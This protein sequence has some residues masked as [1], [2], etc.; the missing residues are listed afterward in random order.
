MT[1]RVI[2]ENENIFD[3]PDGGSCPFNIGGS[4]D[5]L[6][7]VT[8][9][10]LDIP[11]ITG[12]VESMLEFVAA[13]V[14]DIDESIL[15]RENTFAA[16]FWVGGVPPSIELFNSVNKVSGMVKRANEA[17]RGWKVN[18]QNTAARLL[19]ELGNYESVRSIIESSK[20]DNKDITSHGGLK[21]TAKVAASQFLRA[22]KSLTMHHKRL[23]MSN[24]KINIIA[25][26]LRSMINGFVRGIIPYGTEGDKVLNLDEL[27][28]VLESLNGTSSP[29]VNVQDELA[30]I[31]NDGQLVF[32]A[33]ARPIGDIIERDANGPVGDLERRLALAGGG[34]NAQRERNLQSL[35]RAE[36]EVETSL[37]MG[38][39]RERFDKII[40]TLSG[41]FAGDDRIMPRVM[42]L[43]SRIR[44]QSPT[45]VMARLEI[46]IADATVDRLVLRNI[47][48]GILR[49]IRHMRDAD[50][51]RDGF[52]KLLTDVNSQIAHAEHAEN[53]E[54][55]PSGSGVQLPRQAEQP[56]EFAQS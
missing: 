28:A 46:A 38:K 5:P 56:M 32:H 31:V 37:Y 24:A 8:T 30:R 10:F 54:Y 48:N 23:R 41:I 6:I 19:K 44:A 29:L 50:V 15:T 52:G 42:A 55:G 4:G 22:A 26:E 7:T 12:Q 3:C 20:G 1:E 16:K 49:K 21:A 27:F 34:A 25:T 35:E 33:D 14:R 11:K 36:E 47:L 2:R 43:R 17:I 40:S 51:W 45:E 39:T 13:S 9:E 18:L 53:P